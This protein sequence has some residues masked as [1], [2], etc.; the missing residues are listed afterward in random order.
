MK[1]K[2]PT[3]NFFQ[4]SLVRIIVF[5]LITGISIGV[6]LIFKAPIEAFLNNNSIEQ[7]SFDENGLSVHFIDVGQGDSIFIE[8]PDNKTMLIDAGP[9][10]SANIITNYIN[11][12]HITENNVIDYVLLTHSD[13]DHCGAMPNVMSMFEVQMIIRPKIFSSRISGDGEDFVGNKFMCDTLAYA[14]AINSFNDENCPIIFTDKQV[15]NSTSKIEGGINDTY[16]QLVFYSPTEN[17][18]SSSNDYS[19]IFVIEYNNKKI[20]FTGDASTSTENLVMSDTQFPVVDVLKVAHHGSTSSTSLD[21]L[22]QV[23]PNYSIISVG[24][25]NTYGHPTTALLNRLS[26]INS[27]ILRTDIMGTIIVNV[28]SLTS[29]EAVINFN[30]SSNIKVEYVIAGFVLINGYLC[31]FVKYKPIKK[32][33]I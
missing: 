32:Q 30:F 18:Y 11:N 1:K 15:L 10:S 16:Y 20:M 25:N 26:Y 21:F 29:E 12:L 19:P 23:M 33:K 7:K 24:K 22:Y 9:S 3:S 31:F 27:N 2:K 13:E 14:N 5:V 17:Y 8:F 6:G 4:L 28:S